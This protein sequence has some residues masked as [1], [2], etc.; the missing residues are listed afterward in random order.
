MA[1][2]DRKQAV[3]K[4]PSE[5]P[6][7]SRAA[8]IL[9]VLSVATALIVIIPALFKAGTYI[10]GL[11]DSLSSIRRQLSAFDTVYLFKHTFDFPDPSFKF[12]EEELADLTPSPEGRA[13]ALICTPEE[14]DGG[15]VGEELPATHHELFEKI[16][17]YK[18]ELAAFD[19]S[20]ELKFYTIG[21][22]KDE[23]V[24]T[25]IRQETA[26]YKSGQV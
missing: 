5:K 21:G 3:H 19:N 16:N 2:A 24:Q 14:H 4:E 13:R 7:A 12:E 15:V 17:L 26:C 8:K 25:M 20:I 1:N 23:P 10:I 11:H 6:P 22:Q 9:R 18:R